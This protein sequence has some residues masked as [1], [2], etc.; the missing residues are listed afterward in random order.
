MDFRFTEAEEGYREEVRSWLEKNLPDWWD[1]VGER[2]TGEDDDIFP[3]LREWHQKLY[4]A[5]YIGVTWPVEYGGQGRTHVENALLQ[6]ELVGGNAPPTQNGL[7][8]GL[9]GPAIIHHGTEEQ[10]R[11]FLR[12]MLR[13]EE[14]WCQGYS[15]PAAG[16]DL[17]NVQTRAILDGD[18]YVVDG[19]KIWT[20]AA[21][22][23][24]WTFC[25]VRTDPDAAKHDGIGFLLIDMKSPG[26]EVAPLVQITGGR[27]FSQVFYKEVRV[28]RENMVGGPT[29]GWRVANTV[30]GYERGASTLSRYA[31][32][33]RQ[34]DQVVDLAGRSRRDGAVAA[35]DPV[36]RQGIAQ[37]A[38]EVEVL[39]LNSLRSLSALAQGHKPGS[40]SSIQKLY[41][42]EMQARLSRFANELT[43]SYGQL[44]RSE[45]R[46]VDRGRWS[47]REL[48][49]RG[50][51]IFAGTSEIQRNIISERV[52]GLPRR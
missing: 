52:L 28:P 33:K 51:L 50:P 6:E 19:Q 15:E 24:D 39:R 17:A 1:E 9:C 37:L 7:G 2:E 22:L 49:S 11:R 3:K 46:A 21:H 45:P 32:Y 35:A 23:A 29:E 26:I 34:F 16:S 47:Q 43:G 27:N 31:L 14:M 10:K 48:I 18:H 42:S 13:A 30:L 4:D 40:E 20:S 38:I 8:I 25:L 44:A 5:G 41:Y 36:T 12:P